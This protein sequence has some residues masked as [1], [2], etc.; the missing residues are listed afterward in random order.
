MKKL[1][2]LFLTLFILI[3]CE[4]KPSEPTEPS[5]PN[6]LIPLIP[7]SDCAVPT[8]E[9]GWV[10]IWADEFQGD[11]LDMTKWNYEDG[12]YGGGNQEIQYYTRNNTTFEDGKLVITAKNE[13]MMGK[14]Y[15]SSRINT[16][17]KWSDRYVR[18]Q[19][20]AKMPSGRGT[21]PAIWML[22]LMNTY[23]NWPNSGEIDIMEYAGYDLNRIHSTI[24]T[25][26]FNHNLGTQ[27][28]Y[29]RVYPNVETEFKV[30]E[31][32]WAPGHIITYVDGDKLGEFLYV[33][34]LN[35]EVPYHHAHPFDQEFYL[36]INL[37]IGGTFGGVQGVDAS[38]FPTRMEVDYVRVYRQ[39]YALTDLTSPTTPSN[40]QLAQIA[41]TIF[42]NR[43][44][45]DRG[46]EKYAIYLD[47]VFHRYANL[48]QVTF[49][50]LVSNQSYQVEIQA[51]DFVG[52]VSSKS[53]AFTFNFT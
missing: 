50:G 43:S 52:R 20:S 18:I 17:F 39:D 31:M 22:P 32:I 51:I 15:T 34:G 7:T 14:N 8:L 27:I 2:L 6:G 45:D 41:N 28:S 46:V 49:T 47:G 29:T 23:G 21:W 4:A 53:Q 13:Y 38:A 40:I 5:V 25:R 16:R 26:K 37:A 3:G 12:G 10:C 48:N 1:L 36:L 35:R 44:T 42:W 24:H 19:V 33:P 11:E 30:Y 9:D